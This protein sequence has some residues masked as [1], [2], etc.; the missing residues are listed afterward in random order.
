MSMLDRQIE[1]YQGEE[2][3]LLEKYAGKAVIFAEEKMQGVFDDPGVATYEALK[4]LKP[5]EFL[6]RVVGDDVLPAKFFLRV[7]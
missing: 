1:A 2:R 6:I 5:G 3:A 7:G 4:K